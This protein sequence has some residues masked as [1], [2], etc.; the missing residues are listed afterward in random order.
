V[1]YVNAIMNFRFN[2][3]GKILCRIFYAGLCGQ[4]IWG[5][6]PAFRRKLLFP[7]SGKEEEKNKKKKEEEEG[8]GGGGITLFRSVGIRNLLTRNSTGNEEYLKSFGGYFQYMR[9][10][11]LLTRNLIV[12]YVE[13]AYA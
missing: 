3:N 9:P 10:F 8:G 6:L 7:S 2:K 4:V 5:S 13:I 11:G 12:G 1:V